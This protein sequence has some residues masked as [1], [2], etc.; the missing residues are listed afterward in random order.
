M[1]I[2][3]DL[4][5]ALHH[6]RLLLDAIRSWSPACLPARAA[7]PQPG[8][9]HARRCRSAA[10]AVSTGTHRLG[11]R[12]PPATKQRHEPQRTR[13]RVAVTAPEA[14]QG[15]EVALVLVSA[16]QSQVCSAFPSFLSSSR[17]PRLWKRTW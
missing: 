17:F 12:R 6:C 15:A 8:L 9:S 14:R 7:D 11:M 5:A 2:P 16:V 1:R 13:D 4:G 3:F 10:K